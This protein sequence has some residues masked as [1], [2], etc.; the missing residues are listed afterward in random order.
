MFSK[1]IGSLWFC[2]VFIWSE[3]LGYQYI[4]TINIH[5]INKTDINLKIKMN[6]KININIHKKHCPG[7]PDWAATTWPSSAST[8]PG[9]LECSA[10]PAW[11]RCWPKT[12]SCAGCSSSKLRKQKWSW[13]QVFSSQQQ[14]LLPWRR[15]LQVYT[16]P[17]TE[18]IGA[19][20][21][22]IES[23]Q[24]IRWKLKGVFTHNTKLM[25]ARRQ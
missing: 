9:G 24:G 6:I 23:C 10:A 15:G 1:E 18:K 7:L 20:G 5:A 25:F 21:R 22:E 11:R 13:K 12:R 8:S 16:P 17:A 14:S 4:C 19:M 3:T 2:L